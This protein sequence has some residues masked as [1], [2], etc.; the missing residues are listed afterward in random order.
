MKSLLNSD[1]SIVKKSS[2]KFEAWE[3]VVPSR[4]DGTYI[5]LYILGVY[6]S[7]SGESLTID[8]DIIIIKSSPS[9]TTSYT[10][11]SP[12]AI[13]TDWG[14]KIISKTTVVSHIGTSMFNAAFTLSA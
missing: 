9:V 8:G 12:T 13:Q 10:L 14:I 2:V 6:I 1:L 5:S 4:S 3:C 7:S 11:Q